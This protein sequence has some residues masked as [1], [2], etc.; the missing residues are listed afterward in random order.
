MR[1]VCEHVTGYWWVWP[2]LMYIPPS[3]PPPSLRDLVKLR[4]TDWYKVGQKLGFKEDDLDKIH[5]THSKE[6]DKQHAC[7][8][9]MFGQW[10]RRHPYP[11]AHGVIHALRSAGENKAA[12]MLAHKYGMVQFHIIITSLLTCII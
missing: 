4:I 3:V 12:D 9:N 6:R 5:D 8:R 10:L 7:Q 11:H 1:K 2:N